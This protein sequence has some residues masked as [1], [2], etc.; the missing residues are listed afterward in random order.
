MSMPEWLYVLRPL[1][2][3]MLSEG[4]DEREAA[5]LSAHVE[6]MRELSESGVLILAGR[7]QYED[8]RTMGLVILRAENEQAARAVM[9]ADPPVL[10]GIMSAELH[11]Y[12]VAFRSRQ[13]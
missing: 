5:A 2:A 9:E 1:R 11:P 3:G 7:T 8:M 10:A 4:P 12:M 13:L 6:Y